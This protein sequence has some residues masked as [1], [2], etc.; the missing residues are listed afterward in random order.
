MISSM[1]NGLLK[2]RDNRKTEGE[3]NHSILSKIFPF[4]HNHRERKRRMGPA[5]ASGPYTIPRAHKHELKRRESIQKN[6]EFKEEG[7]TA[8]W[9]ARN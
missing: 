2:K 9:R 1:K 6:L 5:T 7:A 4:Y 8:G 3:N